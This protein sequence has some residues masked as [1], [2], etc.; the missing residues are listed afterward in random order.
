MELVDACGKLVLYRA[1]LENFRLTKCSQ[2]ILNV[3]T[4]GNYCYLVEA[5]TL[6]ALETFNG[7]VL[8]GDKLILS[9][10][11]NA[12]KMRYDAFMA[13]SPQNGKSGHISV[14]SENVDGVEV[15]YLRLGPIRIVISGDRSKI[16]MN[17]AVVGCSFI[18]ADALLA[19]GERETL[20]ISGYGSSPNDILDDGIQDKTFSDGL[21]A[22]INAVRFLVGKDESDKLVSISNGRLVELDGFQNYGMSP[23]SAM[24]TANAMPDVWSYVSELASPAD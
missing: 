24:A 16:R 20:I 17:P 11:P 9:R 10:G 13:A 6:A 7:V 3:Q 22:E 15:M 5:P 4:K 18:V 23:F 8:S 19:S 14:I 2:K 1:D 12:M 21:V